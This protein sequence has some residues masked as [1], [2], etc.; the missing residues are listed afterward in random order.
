MKRTP[1]QI[2]EWRDRMTDISRKVSDMS[3]EEKETL[4][5]RIGTMTAE[6]RTLSV[7]NTCFLWMQAGKALAQVGG[8]KQWQRVGRCVKHG[9][10]SIGSILVPMGEGGGG[11]VITN[12]DGTQETKGGRMHFKMV[13]VFDITQTDLIAEAVAA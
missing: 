9:Q 12:E 6:G 10:K 13:P 7:H 11:V 8:F 1:E 3:A 5:C 4:A 2:K